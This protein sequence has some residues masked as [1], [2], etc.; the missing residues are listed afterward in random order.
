MLTVKHIAWTGH[1]TLTDTRR[2][3]YQPETPCTPPQVFIENP[4]GGVFAWAD[5]TV[6]VMNEAGQT[7]SKYIFRADPSSEPQGITKAA[8]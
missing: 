3:S 4:E 1:E 5:G 6:Y 2:V 7:V 8:A